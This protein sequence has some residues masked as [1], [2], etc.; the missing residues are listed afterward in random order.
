MS[1]SKLLSFK[2][3]SR[4]AE[5]KFTIEPQQKFS[6][7]WVDCGL[8]LPADLCLAHH[9][10]RSSNP[11]PAA[12][13]ASTKCLSISR[14]FQASLKLIGSLDRQARFP[15]RIREE[16]SERMGRRQ[17]FRDRCAHRFRGR[18]AQVLRDHR[19]PVHERYS[20]RR[21]C[22][23]FLEDWLVRDFSRFL[24]IVLEAD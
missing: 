20:S 23:Y 4:L 5:K 6:K 7:V 15:D 2:V 24:L 19:L 14:L 8:F 11:K 17:P 22:I 1:Q 18:E 12:A 21:A 3:A 13:A 9:G 16:V 10:D